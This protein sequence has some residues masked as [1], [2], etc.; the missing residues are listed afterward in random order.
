MLCPGQAPF[1]PSQSALEIV[2]AN[3]LS[4]IFVQDLLVF[5]SRLVPDYLALKGLTAVDV[6]QRTEALDALRVLLSR[7][8]GVP[9]GVLNQSPQTSPDVPVATIT[10]MEHDM[11]QFYVQTFF[12]YTSWPPLIPHIPPTL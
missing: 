1:A 3:I 12:E 8:P 6:H 10:A 7:W 4:Q 2:H 11:A 9:D 5:C